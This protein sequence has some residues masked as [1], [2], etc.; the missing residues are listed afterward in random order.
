MSKNRQLRDAYRQP[1]FIPFAVLR[2]VDF[3]VEAFA[4]RLARRRKK[5]FAACVG[6]GIG[7]STISGFSSSATSTARIGAFTWSFSFEGFFAGIARP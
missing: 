1:G 5:R 7:V 4:V 2:S 6:E 3:D